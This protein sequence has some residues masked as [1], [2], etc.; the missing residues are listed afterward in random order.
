MADSVQQ[1]VDDLR[2]EHAE[3]DT[4]VASLDDAGWALATSAVGWDVRDSIGHLAF[5]DDLAL[6]CVEERSDVLAA[7]L[8]YGD[9]DRYNEV[10]VAKGRAMRPAEVLAWWRT[11]RERLNRA[12]LGLRPGARI[13][14]VSGPMS[15]RM[16]VMT[17][18]VETWAHGLDCHA[19]LGV[20]P[21]DTDRLRH[22]CW[23][24][25]LVLPYAFDVADRKMPGDLGDLRLELTGPAGQ[26]WI[27]GAPNAPQWIKGDAVEW[28]RVAA[29]RLPLDE[30]AS[31]S[32]HG[33][34]AAAALEVARAYM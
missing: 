21:K 6:A 19:A 18:L 17:R 11:S 5:I 32:A 31:L 29:Q 10:G 28:A 34:L 27:V 26:T 23:V 20:R 30:A 3:L 22:V 16:L 2:R 15:A 7:T 1:I 9:M 14:W 24:S 25:Y 13:R 12:F 8:A 4:L 33:A